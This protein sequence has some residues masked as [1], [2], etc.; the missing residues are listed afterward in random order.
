M[1]VVRQGSVL[2]AFLVVLSIGCLR[3]TRKQLDQLRDPAFLAFPSLDS[4][5]NVSSFL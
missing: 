1:L 3:G 4:T 5:S 2:V